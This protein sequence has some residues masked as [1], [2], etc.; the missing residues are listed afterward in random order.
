MLKSQVERLKFI[1][2]VDIIVGIDIAKE[3]HWARILTPYGLEFCKPFPINDNIIDFKK[4]EEKIKNI[5]GKN[6]LTNVII[7]MEATGPYGSKL[8]KFLREAKFYVV[9][10]NSHHVKKAKELDDNTP[11]KND[12]KDAL[13]IANLIKE[14]RY[15]DLY[16][17]EGIYADMRVLTTTRQE[18]LKVKN[19][20]INKII[21]I[22]DQYFPEFQ[23]VFKDITKITA[24]QLL[25]KYPLPEDLVNIEIEELRNN[26][27][28]Y[29]GKRK[30]YI[31]KATAIKI[32]A[33]N[34][35]GITAD[36][37]YVKNNIKFLAAQLQSVLDNL[38]Y[39]EQQMEEKLNQ[40]PE[41]KYIKS[42]E[43]IG[44]IFCAGLIGELG[45]IKRFQDWK[46]IRKYAGYNF[47]EESSGKKKGQTVISKRGRSLL[48]YILYNIGVSLISN[49]S[50][51]KKLF[52]Y[53]KTRKKN[54][55]KGTQAVI[56]IAMKFLRVLHYVVVNEVMYDSSKVLGEYREHQIAA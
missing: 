18:W 6:N 11:S 29:D 27:R 47:T 41:S 26:I 8:V 14:G 37:K 42:I 2:N 32:F 54:P 52:E 20:C 44:N 23:D 24:M 39:I 51:F 46:Q 55:L 9:H 22:L 30:M 25:A 21:G 36:V 4:L 38:G 45:E 12:R 53:F 15:Y 13:T 56:A 49:N 16:I 48:R 33:E 5:M 28:T 35:I 3:T 34:T 31:T 17:P 7:G 10:V 43:G 1:R 50:E 40:L 19:Q